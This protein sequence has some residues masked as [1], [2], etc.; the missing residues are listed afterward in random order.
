M[1]TPA[2]WY[3]DGSGNRRWWDGE[4]WTA[5]VVAGP[6][7][8]A[9]E[10]TGNPAVTAGEAAEPAAPAA[11]AAPTE[12][13]APPFVLDTLT[14]HP[15]SQMGTYPGTNAGGYPAAGQPVAP[16]PTPAPTAPRRI[17]VLGL[18]GLI[19][20]AVGVVLACIPPISAVGWIVLGVAFVT[21]IVSLFLRGAKWPGI[22]GVGVTVIGAILA[23][24]VSL[25]SLG[26]SSIVEAGGVQATPS[27][28]PS[29]D[30]GAADPAEDPSEIE[31][32][33]MVPFDRLAVGDCIPLVEYEDEIF[34]VPVVPCDRPHTDEVY[35]IY[36]FDDGEY[37]GDDVLYQEAEERCLAEFEGFVGMSYEQS[38]LDFY[39]YWPTQMS[40]NRMDDR[41]VHCIVFSYDDVTGTLEGAD[42]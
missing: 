19:A 23:L 40:W 34:E 37:P 24:A 7:P 6:Q 15:I 22:T 1:T 32:A 17:S 18:I 42:R 14:A 30:D 29:V 38:E 8:A 26:F 27:E 9:D 2:G 10:P 25:V 28:R 31:G 12:V 11:P 5:H 39:T 4:Q 21:S 20:A 36:Q 13:F 41:T 33:R 35:F 3:D 16:A